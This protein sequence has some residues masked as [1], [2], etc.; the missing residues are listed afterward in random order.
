MA[1]AR[2][3]EKMEST[4]QPPSAF[5]MTVA[6]GRGRGR[7]VSRKEKKGL[8]MAVVAEAYGL[9]TSGTK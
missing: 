4:L 9:L 8:S 3:R 6:K 1:R 7:E 5:F 2:E